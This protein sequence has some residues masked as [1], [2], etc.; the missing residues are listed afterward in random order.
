MLN[1]DMKDLRRS[2]QRGATVHSNTSAQPSMWRQ[3]AISLG[4]STMGFSTPGAARPNKAGLVE[5]N[6]SLNAGTLRGVRP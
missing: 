3:L 4:I 6:V 1:Q 5:Q 2:L